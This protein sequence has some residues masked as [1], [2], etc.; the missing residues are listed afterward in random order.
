MKVQ[1]GDVCDNSM[2][3]DDEFQVE[4]DK[5]EMTLSTNLSDDVCKEMESSHWRLSVTNSSLFDVEIDLLSMI[6]NKRLCLY[7]NRVKRGR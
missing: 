1:P 7:H 4:N 2:P 5:D 6:E 3:T